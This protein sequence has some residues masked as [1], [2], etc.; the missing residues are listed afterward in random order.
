MLL[1]CLQQYGSWMARQVCQM[2]LQL[3]PHTRPVRPVDSDTSSLRSWRIVSKVGLA[4]DD[5]LMAK[6]CVARKLHVIQ[7]STELLYRPR[8]LTTSVC[9]TKWMPGVW[10]FNV[11][12]TC[13][14]SRHSQANVESELAQQRRRVSMQSEL[15]V[16]DLVLSS[17]CR[18]SSKQS[19]CR[20]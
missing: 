13:G 17:R 10:T 8:E 1:Q 7:L 19:T 9:T 20:S 15:L 2:D 18:S 11:R 14:I 4:S 12:T 6:Q 16:A 5:N 3:H